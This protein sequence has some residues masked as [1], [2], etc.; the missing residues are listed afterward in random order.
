LRQQLHGLTALVAVQVPLFLFVSL[1]GSSRRISYSASCL[2]RLVLHLNVACTLHSHYLA[3]IFLYF[4]VYLLRTLLAILCSLVVIV[5]QYSIFLFVVASCS[6]RFSSNF[7]LF[8]RSWA[9]LL[10]CIGPLTLR[11][12]LLTLSFVDARVSR[13]F[14]LDWNDRI[15]GKDTVLQVLASATEFIPAL[16]FMPKVQ[17]GNGHQLSIYSHQRQQIHA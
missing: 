10:L 3:A 7:Q 4:F 9:P 5:V 6:L 11:R 12:G 14:L 15:Q 8:C 16:S 1:T 17:D 13:T 2:Q